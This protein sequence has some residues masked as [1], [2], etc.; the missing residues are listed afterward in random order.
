MQ[1]RVVKDMTDTSYMPPNTVLS[2][3]VYDPRLNL[4]KK[5]TKALLTSSSDHDDFD[6]LQNNLS[7]S[8]L[9]EDSVRNFVNSSKVKVSFNILFKF[10]F[11]LCSNYLILK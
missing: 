1:N 9:F 7:L 2:V 11:L 6:S 4:P 10:L 3:I 8:P 5:R